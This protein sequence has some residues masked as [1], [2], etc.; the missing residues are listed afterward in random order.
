MLFDYNGE[1]LARPGELDVLIKEGHKDTAKPILVSL[2]SDLGA[3]EWIRV[4]AEHF[5]NTI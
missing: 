4:M 2:S 3:P 1:N 5:L